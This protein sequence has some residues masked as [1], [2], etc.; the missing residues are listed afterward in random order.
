MGPR[1]E[2]RTAIAAM[3]RTGQRTSNASVAS[4]TSVKRFTMAHDP[5]N[6]HEDFGGVKAA[7]IAP[8]FRAVS[9]CFQRPRMRVIPKLTPVASHRG[10]LSLEASRDVHPSVGNEAP[11]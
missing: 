5:S 8:R 11:R 3:R 2:K 7:L 10:E 9:E 4:R 6:G 1:L